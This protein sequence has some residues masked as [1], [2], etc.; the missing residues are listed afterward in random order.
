MRANQRFD[1]LEQHFGL[2]RIAE[3]VYV[4]HGAMLL[5]AEA[6]AP[7][8]EQGVHQVPE[9]VIN[10][11]LRFLDAVDA[12]GVHRRGND[13]ER[14]SAPS[15]RRPLPASPIVVMPCS[16]ALANAASR[17]SELPLVEMPISPSPRRPWAMSWRTK[18]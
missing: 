15:C 11:D 10:R 4:F 8:G 12:V 17:F 1:L 5:C 13:R 2:R 3:F 7:I 6:A 9:N 14:G 16:F 18:I